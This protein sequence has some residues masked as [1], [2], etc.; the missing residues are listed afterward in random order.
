M[1]SDLPSPTI[2]TLFSTVRQESFGG[3]GGNGYIGGNGGDAASTMTNLSA[4]RMEFHIVA[5]GGYGGFGGTTAAAFD[6][7]GGNGG[8][9]TINVDA[10][11]TGDYARVVTDALGG[12]GG[13]GN[14][15][16]HGGNASIV[17][18]ASTALGNSR[19]ETY[20]DAYAIGGQGGVMYN[21][22]PSTTIPAG[23]AGSA[24][25]SA[26]S[27]A[28]GDSP[29]TAHSYA[30]AGQSG[31]GSRATGG[32]GIGW[33]GATARAVTFG[34][35]VGTNSVEVISEVF[36]GSGGGG[37]VGG[38]GGLA[39]IDSA[40]G[41]S[42]AGKV[43]VST[44]LTGGTGGY[45]RI[46]GG[47]GASV[48]LSNVS[49]GTTA[50]QLILNQIAIGG[51]GGPVAGD[52]A[53]GT[54]G[55]AMSTLVLTNTNCASL[56][57]SASATSGGAG[58]LLGSTN[59]AG[60]AGRAGTAFASVQLTGAHDV[61]AI[62]T[63]KGGKTNLPLNRAIAVAQSL[64]GGIARADATTSGTNAIDAS[65][66][67]ITSLGKVL[68][69]SATSSFKLNSYSKAQIGL[70]HP[71][72]LNIARDYAYLTALPT[73]VDSLSALTAH[74]HLQAD[75]NLGQGVGSSSDMLGLVSL[76]GPATLNGGWSTSINESLDLSQFS[77]A[78]HLFIGLATARATSTGPANLHFSISREGAMLIDQTFT[79]L[80]DATA[81]FT[82][83]SLDLGPLDPRSNGHLDLTIQLDATQ[84]PDGG[85]A[86]TL[87]I[88]NATPASGIPEPSSTLLLTLA[89]TGLL[90]RRRRPIF[91]PR[92]G[93]R[94]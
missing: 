10:H 42:T 16:A 43:T 63:V 75:I 31:V 84:I 60:I 66:L 64:N 19:F 6:A 78:Q 30:V 62:A 7:A 24:F 83:N 2:D 76:A 32:P 92:S 17:S 79:T 4:R 80:A 15:G 25:A 85:F 49:S 37:N 89:T 55:D 90:T 77:S 45:G 35:N 71:S 87:L 39:L 12:F 52:G 8:D 41:F 20:A 48:F 69:A 18:K 11:C 29:V 36:G 9:A 70:P 59:V 44:T 13:L 73:L 22:P 72:V 14:A 23:I 40:S 26:T 61:S 65:T 88:A 81:Y 38:A 27:I 56:S 74:P 33:G 1:V 21:L 82:D 47:N 28:A 57:G 93:G 94:L 51:N 58:T 46:Q 34:S 91:K 54:G 5:T 68:N 50:G 67:A 53:G 86:T 3:Y